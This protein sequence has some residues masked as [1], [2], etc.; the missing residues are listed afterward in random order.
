MVPDPPGDST[1]LRY[2]IHALAIIGANHQFWHGLYEAGP[3][4]RRYSRPGAGPV[5][6]VC[7]GHACA[8]CSAGLRSIRPMTTERIPDLVLEAP[9][10]RLVRQLEC[11]HRYEHRVFCRW[12]EVPFVVCLP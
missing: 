7:S 2:A 3:K 1:G 10:T 5:A 9:N 12:F 6:P 4:M 11:T 8:A